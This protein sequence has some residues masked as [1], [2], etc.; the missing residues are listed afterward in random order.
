MHRLMQS[1]GQGSSAAQ[2]DWEA[3]VLEWVAVAGV[4]S[5]IYDQ[6]QHRFLQARSRRPV[7]PAPASHSSALR[8]RRNDDRPGAKPTDRSERG[9]RHSMRRH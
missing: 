8:F 5:Q 1:M 7:P 2:S 9:G 6:L 3:L 4:A